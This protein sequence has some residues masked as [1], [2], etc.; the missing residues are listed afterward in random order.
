MHEPDDG[1]DIAIQSLLGRRAGAFTVS[2]VVERDDVV[3][4]LPE[5]DEHVGPDRQVAAV[6]VEV[7]DL[8]SRIVSRKMPDVDVFSV[9]TSSRWRGTKGTPY[10]AGVESW[11]R[12][13][14][15]ARCA[16]YVRTSQRTNAIATITAPIHQSARRPQIIVTTA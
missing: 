2:T 11:P 16:S 12:I 3:A 14:K 15:N 1:V 4:L 7:D 5:A 10:A 9:G 8:R 13:G 6:A